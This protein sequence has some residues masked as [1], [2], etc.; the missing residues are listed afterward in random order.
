MSL[1]EFLKS[2][3]SPETRYFVAGP[4]VLDSGRRLDEVNVAYRT[5]GNPAN[6][7][8]RAVLICHALTGS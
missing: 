6:A 1:P 3:L 2:H 5:W 8:Q 4:F 7:A